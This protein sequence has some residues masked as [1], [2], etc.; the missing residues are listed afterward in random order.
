MGCVRSGCS[1]CGTFNPTELL[2]AV[3]Q[4]DYNQNDFL[5]GMWTNLNSAL[6][7]AWI[8]TM[9]GYSAPK[10]DVEALN[11]MKRG[12]GSVENRELEDVEIVNIDSED[13]ML[14]A[15]DA[16]IH[17]HHHLY[18]QDFYDSLIPNHPRRTCEVNWAR[19]MECK[20]VDNHPLPKDADF[21]ELWEWFGERLDVE[22][23]KL[24]ERGMMKG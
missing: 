19:L 24:D 1:K 6:E 15:F 10:T 2:Y 17:T 4:K 14:T 11:L 23:Q 16:F 7:V 9:F 22:R 12:W 21:P 20:F 18:A 8:I 5:K 13:N 3:T